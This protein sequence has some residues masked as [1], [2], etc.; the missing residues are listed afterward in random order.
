MKTFKQYIKIQEAT[1][2]SISLPQ[3]IEK[4]TQYRLKVGYGSGADPRKSYKQS[5]I[6]QSLRLSIKAN[7]GKFSAKVFNDYLMA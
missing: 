5:D 7:G 1:E 3:A 2:E 6:E 4:I